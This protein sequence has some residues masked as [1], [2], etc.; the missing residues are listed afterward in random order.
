MQNCARISPSEKPILFISVSIGWAIRN[1]FQT[2][3]VENL[4]AHFEVIAL[5]TPKAKRNLC[6]LGFDQSITIIEVEVGKEPLT[7]MLFRQLKKKIY[8]E[9]RH[10]STEAIWEKYYPRPLYQRGG[11]KIIK[12]FLGLLNVQRLYNMVDWLDLKINKDMRLA[13]I[14][15]EHRPAIFFATHA[16]AYFE[17]CLLRNALE[18][19]VPSIYMILSWDHLSSK[20]LL[21]QRL[22]SVL[23][24]NK[25]TKNEVLKTYPHYQDKQIRVV[26]IPQYDLYAEKPNI[27]Y[28]DWCRKY[29]LDPARRTILFSTMPQSRHEQQH[30]ILEELL[31]IIIGGKRLPPD[32]QIL[33]KCHPFD[34]FK[35]YDS[36]LN[37]Y[38]VGIHRNSF[39]ITQTQEDWMPALSEMEASRDAL[40]FCTL[41]INIFSTVT[42][43]AA[44]FDKPVVHIAF[45]PQPIKDRIPCHE[46]YNWDHFK[47]IVDIG[48]TVLV[49]NF[50]ELYDAINQLI[51]QP[52]LFKEQRR[53]LVAKYIGK[54]VGKAST[55]VVLELTDIYKELKSEQS[56]NAEP[57]QIF[58]T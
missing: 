12:S 40:Y 51:S 11:G 36:L 42:I 35:G 49:H 43:E 57:T 34:N 7:W 5:T 16:T 44:Y 18:A 13:N 45:D 24:W 37:D 28:A 32:L 33:I 31:K 56:I 47:P 48:A 38:P 6:E 27:T 23:V 22:H 1:F 9:G 52:S 39:D 54:E 26:G 19:N 21:N 17:E 25:H 29:D 46:Y 15:Q 20:I 8:M 10:S 50:E 41:N 3:I 14:F 2:G 30:I 58:P 55:S 4:K 53:Q